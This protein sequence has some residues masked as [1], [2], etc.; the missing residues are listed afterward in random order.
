MVVG[1]GLRRNSEI[2][3][4]RLTRFGRQWGGFSG[5]VAPAAVIVVVLIYLPFCAAIV[6]SFLGMET[7][8]SSPVFVG[9]SNFATALGDSEFWWALT[10]GLLYAGASLLFEVVL[11][12]GFALLLN[13]RLPA[14]GLLRGIA[15]LPYVV[16]T[17]VGVFV[18]RL[19][20][21]ENGGVVTVALRS[22][23]IHVPWFSN[24]TWAMVS[25]VVISVWLWTPFV[26]IA[27]LGGLQTI[28]NDLY[29]AAKVD[30]AGAW[31]RFV[32][33]TVPGLAPVLSVVA[34]LRGIWM[35]NKFDVI[36]LATG[37]GPLKATEHLPIMA[38]R[39]A[40]GQLKLGYG[41]A[42]ACLN[43]VVLAGVLALGVLVS[44]R[45]NRE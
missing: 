43:F 20:L 17:V 22:L 44:R 25:V 21:D 15:I 29:E 38:Y 27:A 14:R 2:R 18:W 32:N 11:G 45:M 26:T 37:G 39:E 33:V 12:V 6:L 28:R 3:L 4:A 1:A 42:I 16:P 30:G 34:L 24:P 10:H 7:I 41:A 8:V 13:E 9:L 31:Q 36:Y 19:I 5:V 40:F 23:G 35:F